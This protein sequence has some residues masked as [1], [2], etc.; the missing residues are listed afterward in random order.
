MKAILD[1]PQ[2][3]NLNASTSDFWFLAAALKDFVANEGNG[4]LP[5]QGGIPDMTATTEGYLAL[6]RL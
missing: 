6:Q 2:C 1:D 3:S 4:L 5:V